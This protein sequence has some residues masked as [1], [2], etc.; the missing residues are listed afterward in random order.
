MNVIMLHLH[1]VQQ[2]KGVDEWKRGDGSS[3]L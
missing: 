1:L 2:G 3:H